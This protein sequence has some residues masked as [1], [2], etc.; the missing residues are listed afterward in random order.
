M[1]FSLHMPHSPKSSGEGFTLIELLVAVLLLT[2]GGLLV[3]QTT[4]I[5][6]SS[7]SNASTLTDIRNAVSRDLNWIRWY[8]KAWNVAPQATILQYT[9]VRCNTL[10]A[11]F[12][13]DASQSV[14][15]T[16]ESA[17]PPRPNPIPATAGTSQTLQ[18]LNG[19]TLSR[20]INPRPTSSGSLPKSIL[21]SYVYNGNPAFTVESS[22]LIDAA[23]WC[24]PNPPS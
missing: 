9:S 2:G 21:V 13:V 18:T 11:N 16:S 5:S 6:L 1:Q 15:P 8:A 7:S 12:I 14:P 24:D 20:T 3:A 10:V 19:N 22:V 4:R 23:G 17:A